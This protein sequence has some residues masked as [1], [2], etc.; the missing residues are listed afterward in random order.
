MIENTENKTGAR[1]R[2][3]QGA[4]WKRQCHSSEVQTEIQRKEASK[5]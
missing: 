2:P 5:I 3:T 4:T 1:W